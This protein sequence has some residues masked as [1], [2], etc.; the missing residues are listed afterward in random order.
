MKILLVID[1]FG[2]GGAQRQIVELA[3]GLK[4]RGHEVEMFVYYPQHDFFR[5]RVEKQQIVIH[6]YSKVR[7]FSF[8]VAFRLA[9]LIRNGG[10]DIVVSYLK[11]TN[12]YAELAKLLSG[13][14][15]LIVSERTSYHD[16]KSWIAAIGRRMMH[17]VANQVVAN[18]VTQSDWLKRKWWLKK[19]VTCIYNGLD[20]NAFSLSQSATNGPRNPQELRLIGI[21]RIGPE[22]NIINLIK[23]LELLH[24]DSGYIPQISWAGRRDESRAGR[25]YCRKIDEL[26]ENLPEIQS[27]WHW[28]GVKSDVAELLQQYHALI[29]PSSYEGLPNVVCEGL[30]AGLPV[31]VSDV[32][33]HSLLVADG[34]RGFLFDPHDPESIAIA[35]SDLVKI[36]ADR[37]L[38]FSQNAREYAKT[39]LS[40]EKM[41]VEYENLFISLAGGSAGGNAQREQL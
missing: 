11:S 16:D 26:L 32:C 25:V 9:S 3:C 30:A 20:L 33:D 24:A 34:E 39:Y 27:R 15:T 6:E 41:I 29:H 21:G 19:K 12:F 18:S 31:L 7:R 28:L 13:G 38:H 17:V 14:A 35:I 37:W 10:F 8:G 2:L 36:D 22:K 40:V 4:K 23:A 5:S 1:H